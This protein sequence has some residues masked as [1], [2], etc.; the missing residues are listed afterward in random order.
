M[1]YREGQDRA[2]MSGEAW[3]LLK[4]PYANKYVKKQETVV[5][6]QVHFRAR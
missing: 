1:S 6:V 3:G 4:V 2:S 5:I